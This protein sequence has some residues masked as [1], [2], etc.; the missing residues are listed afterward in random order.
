[1]EQQTTFEP[2][3]IPL[4]VV[5]TFCKRHG[6]QTGTQIG[7]LKE[8]R[9]LVISKW[10]DVEKAW[11]DASL[12]TDLMADVSARFKTICKA[13]TGDREGWR[14]AILDAADAGPILVVRKGDS[15]DC[16]LKYGLSGW[17]GVEQRWH[18][19]LLERLPFRYWL[20]HIATNNEF[21]L[22]LYLEVGAFGEMMD[23]WLEGCL[24]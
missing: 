13:L 23:R 16:L 9:M 3:I 14:Y 4:Y 1:M 10:E 12:G 7:T 11:L 20:L 19:D 15:P 18:P 2:D 8:V 17:G 24:P 5:E 6:T 22:V 21:V